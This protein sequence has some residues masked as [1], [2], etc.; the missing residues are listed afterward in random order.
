MIP[1]RIFISL[2][3]SLA[4]NQKDQSLF[5]ISFSKSLSLLNR[6]ESDKNILKSFS[7]LVLSVSGELS[8]SSDTSWLSNTHISFFSLI[9]FFELFCFLL[10]LISRSLYSHSLWNSL[11]IRFR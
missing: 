2:N 5:D 7:P 1:S 8:T 6:S 9:F 3:P 4:L 11:S 10:I